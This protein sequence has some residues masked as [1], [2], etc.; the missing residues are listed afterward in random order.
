MMALPSGLRVLVVED[1]MLVSMLFED[2]LVDLGCE[3]VG[4][5]ERVA[6]GTTLAASERIDCALLDINVAG[7]D[8]YPVATALARRGIPFAF[9]TG[10]HADRAADEY[11]NRPAL[12]K[13]VRIAELEKVIRKALEGQH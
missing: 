4:P 6:K 10:Y 1:D 12:Q 5:A 11:R 13:P 3:V 2:M 9:V 8:V 7:E